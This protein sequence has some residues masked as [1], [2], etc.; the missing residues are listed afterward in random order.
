M[1]MTVCSAK[2]AR[3]KDW[4][5]LIDIGKEKRNAGFAGSASTGAW[6][7]GL[8]SIKPPEP[9]MNEYCLSFHE[10]SDCS[11]IA[12]TSEMHNASCARFHKTDDGSIP[13]SARSGC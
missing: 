2:G 5:P 7:P 6:M 9:G 4:L 10:T 3:L 11:R 12:R 1:C 13:S 8:L